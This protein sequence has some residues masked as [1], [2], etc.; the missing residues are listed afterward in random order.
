MSDKC[1]LLQ[2][3][4]S[5]SMRDEQAQRSRAR[6]GMHICAQHTSAVK[7]KQTLMREH[8]VPTV[9]VLEP[10]YWGNSGI[11]ENKMETTIIW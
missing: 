2:P 7:A 4:F 3:V 9:T 11:M 6:V 10:L 1:F 8:S 5:T